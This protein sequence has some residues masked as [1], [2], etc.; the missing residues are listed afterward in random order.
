MLCDDKGGRS[1]SGTRTGIGRESTWNAPIRF[2]PNVACRGVMIAANNLK[3]EQDDG[4][5]L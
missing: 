3:N 5:M 2:L 1:E 4:F